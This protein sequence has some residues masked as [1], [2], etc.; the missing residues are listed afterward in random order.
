MLKDIIIVLAW[1]L[2]LATAM[3]AVVYFCYALLS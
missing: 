2:G 3:V 1:T